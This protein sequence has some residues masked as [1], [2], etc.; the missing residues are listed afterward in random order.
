MVRSWE[1]IK[2]SLL[3]ETALDEEVS[4]WALDS[5]NEHEIKNLDK[6]LKEKNPGQDNLREL[7]KKLHEIKKKVKQTISTKESNLDDISLSSSN[8][9]KLQISVPSNLNYL[10]KA[11]AAAE[12]RDLSSVAMQCLEVG[13]RSMKNKGAIP[14]SAI[15]KYE[16]ACEKRIALAEV[17]HAWNIHQGSYLEYLNKNQ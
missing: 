14:S 8:S 7:E 9:S 6:L 13:L 12:G 1:E 10:M 17:N 11:W 15:K 5:I 2:D 3:Q 4:Q 16:I